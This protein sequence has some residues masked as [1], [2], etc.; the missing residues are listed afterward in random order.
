[1]KYLV[2]CDLDESLLN[3]KGELTKK[4]IQTLN[5]V[6]ELGHIV[7]LATGRPYVG[8]IGKY[9]EI[10]LDTP[11]ITDNGGS[12]ENPQ[13][14][15]FPKQKTFIPLHI[16]HQIFTFSKPF[17]ESAFFSD[18]QV[19]YTYRPSTL[20]QG[21]FSGTLTE[22]IIE[23]DFTHVDVEPTGMAFLIHSQHEKDLENYI[24]THFPETISHRLWGAEKG[25]SVYEIYLKRISKSSAIKY[26]LEY[27]DLSFD[28]VIAFGD[29]SNDIEMIRDARLGVAMLNGIDDLKRVAR[30]ITTFDNDHDGVAHYLINFFNLE[31]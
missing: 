25:F 20:L 3:K 6:R 23:T 26:L 9:N 11:L 4:T 31:T 24:D 7:V 12:I 19:V 10:G 14:A 30:D 16:M 2:A 13:D 15:S 27:Y 29:G 8:T 28:N 18:D 1:M 17:L 22:E 5:K 21:Y